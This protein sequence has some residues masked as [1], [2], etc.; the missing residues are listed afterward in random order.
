[1]GGLGGVNAGNAMRSAL[2]C[3]H[4]GAGGVRQGSGRDLGGG[5]GQ[6]DGGVG[7]DG[8]GVGGIGGS[9]F[10]TPL[11]GIELYVAACTLSL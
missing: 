3:D 5:D 2:E 7:V 1:M 8:E 9:H 4:P 11:T 10:T 6:A